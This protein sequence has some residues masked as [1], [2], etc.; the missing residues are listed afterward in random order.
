MRGLHP[1]NAIHLSHERAAMC[2]LA[3]NMTA[4]TI[5]AVGLRIEVKRRS[6][7]TSA[8]MCLKRARNLLVVF[9]EPNTILLK[10]PGDRNCVRSANQLLVM[11]F[12][13]KSCC[14]VSS[15]VWCLA[16]AIGS[17]CIW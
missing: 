9:V 1:G 15:L 8:F 10:K 4:E 11:I 5:E 12:S 6:G 14:N 17:G 7:F 13:C 3:A 16:V 2:V